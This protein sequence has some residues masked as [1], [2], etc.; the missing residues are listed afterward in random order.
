MY[1]TASAS[2]NAPVP[3]ATQYLGGLSNLTLS[4]L[5]QESAFSTANIC[6][7]I[8]LVLIQHWLTWSMCMCS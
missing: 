1:V 8:V 2:S 3:H 5:M 6:V 7:C 4:A